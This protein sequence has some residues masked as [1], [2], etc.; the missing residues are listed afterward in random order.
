MQLSKLSPN[1]HLF[2]KE[3]FWNVRLT[4]II[5]TDM[6]ILGMIILQQIRNCWMRANIH[7]L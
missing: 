3:F 6:I 1:A 5:F 4:D 2:S 7:Y